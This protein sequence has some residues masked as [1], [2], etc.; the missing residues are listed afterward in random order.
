MD[1]T[2]YVLMDVLS[3]LKLRM[4]L[5]V[6]GPGFDRQICKTHTIFLQNAPIFIISPS[7]HSSLVLV[8]I[9]FLSYCWSLTWQPAY[10][11]S[12]QSA[13]YLALVLLSFTWELYSTADHAGLHTAV[14]ML[15][16]LPMSILIT[17]LTNS[18]NVNQLYDH[19]WTSYHCPYV[20]HS[21]NVQPYFPLW[22]LFECQSTYN[23]RLSICYTLL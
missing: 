7:G 1:V 17:C 21:Y 5:S 3:P 13:L 18:W 11:H 19:P 2:Y 12:Q 4:Y 14:H 23:Q 10:R 22:T 9:R 6:P 15:H 20:T 8:V 16:T